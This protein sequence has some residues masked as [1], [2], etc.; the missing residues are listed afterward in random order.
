MR[1]GSIQRRSGKSWAAGGA[2][3]SAAPLTLADVAL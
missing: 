3:I 1:P 2:D